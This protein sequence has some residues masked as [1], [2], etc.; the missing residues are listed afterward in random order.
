MLEQGL[1]DQLPATRDRWNICDFP[2][3]VVALEA[4]KPLIDAAAAM[5]R[6]GMLMVHCP[7]IRG[8]SAKQEVYLDSEANPSRITFRQC[9]PMC[10]PAGLAGERIVAFVAGAL[11]ATTSF[12]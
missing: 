2:G 6:D 8:S 7:S 11:S 12:L 4:R 9:D 10:L 3:T 1:G 5:A